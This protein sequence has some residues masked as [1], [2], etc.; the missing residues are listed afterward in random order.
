MRPSNCTTNSSKEYNE[1]G[2]SVVHRGT[3]YSKRGV[4][5][6]T[7]QPQHYNDE[8]CLMSKVTAPRKDHRQSQSIGRSDDFVVAQRS[9]RLNHGCSAGGGGGF[10]AVGKR[11]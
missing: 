2:V 8:P 4:S 9:T 1:T 11:E 10:D 6:D 7:L 3:I 5:I